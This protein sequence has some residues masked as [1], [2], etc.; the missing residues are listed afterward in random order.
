MSLSIVL[1]TMTDKNATDKKFLIKNHENVHRCIMNMLC[2]IKDTLLAWAPI[3]IIISK[4]DLMS[5]VD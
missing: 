3:E 2:V 5:N 1:N 4:S